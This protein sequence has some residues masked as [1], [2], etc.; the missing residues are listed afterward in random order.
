[1]SFAQ[2]QTPAQGQ[3]Q[4]QVPGPAQ[5]QQLLN[6]LAA[7]N[8]MNAG[9]QTQGARAPSRWER[10]T[11]IAPIELKAPRSLE[12]QQ[13]L[14]QEGF[15]VNPEQLAKIMKITRRPPHNKLLAD[16][17]SKHGLTHIPELNSIPTAKSWIEN[18]IQQAIKAR[19][20]KAIERW[21]KYAVDYQDFDE[22]PNTIDNV[23]VYKKK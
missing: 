11:E 5:Q 4:A 7:R 17:V 20:Q 6:I 22:N 18:K 3:A 21:S 23:V 19:D 16:V 2:G 8:A 9:V 12:I 14:Q 10:R 15:Q 13:A 1:M